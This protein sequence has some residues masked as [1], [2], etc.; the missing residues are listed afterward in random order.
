MN[1]ELVLNALDGSNPLAFLAAVGALRLLT[2]EMKTEIQMGW[3]RQ[4]GFSRPKIRSIAISKGDLCERLAGSNCWAPVEDMIE[5]LGNNVNLT[6]SSAIFKPLVDKGSRSADQ[7]DR[8]MADFSAAFGSEVC[9]EERNDRIER[10]DFCF[11]TG[12]GHQD[13]LGT[14]A[15]LKKCVISEHIYDALFG[16]WKME[17][18]GSMR[19]DPS[20]AAEY[21]L[22]WDDPGPK[23]AWSVWGAN[24]LALEALPC[25][26]TVPARSRWHGITLQ[27]T[28]FTW[29]EGKD[30]FTWP[31]W[32]DFIGLAS[33][34][35]LVAHAELQKNAQNRGAKEEQD[36]EWLLA[37]GVTEIY[38]AQRIRIGQGANFKVSFRPARAV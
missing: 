5:L 17:R 24:R 4:G 16:D 3:E 1:D 10:T 9:E 34:K 23:G 12:S 11:I 36:R 20:D 28:G 21:A 35:S 26:P 25:F 8:R 27:T 19:W 18:K 31:L 2:L 6:V 22:Q 13:F 33:I 14:M 15:D 7:R 38:R 32:K 29:R 30:E 37:M